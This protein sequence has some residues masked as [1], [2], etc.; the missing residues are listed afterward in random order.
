MKT[1]LWSIGVLI[2]LVALLFAIQFIFP[3]HGPSQAPVG[4]TTYDALLSDN[5]AFAQADALYAA[6]NVAGAESEL[7][8]ALQN[9]HTPEE[10][11]QI[12]I[13]LAT[14]IENGFSD[15]TTALNAIPLLKQIAANTSYSPIIR[16]SAI[17][18]MGVAF[19]NTGD[20]RFTDAIFSNDALYSTMFVSGDTDLSYRHLFQYAASIYPLAYSELR[21]AKWYSGRI[22]E[23]AQAAS[24]NSAAHLSADQV[25]SYKDMIRQEIAAA[26]TDEQR[27]QNDPHQNRIIPALIQNE[28]ILI[29]RMQSIGDDSFGDAEPLFQRALSLEAAAK[30]PL[31]DGFT[32]YY[33]AAFLAQRYGTSRASDVQNILAPFYTS[34]AYQGTAAVREFGSERNNILGDKPNLQLLA[35]VDPKFKAYLISLGWTASDFK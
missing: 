2:V 13:K 30:P 35:S 26:H 19:Y 1:F 4:V 3:A 17:Q 8:S 6:G 5:P 16:A 7:N 28:A 18:E 23:S 10:A 15:P 12:Q 20:K 24:S 33:Y 25:S 9:A 31:S 14:V 27:I 32:R 11:G 29:G 34:D 21:I 22:Y